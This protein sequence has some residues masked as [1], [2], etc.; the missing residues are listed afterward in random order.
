VESIALYPTPGR[1][2]DGAMRARLQC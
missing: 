1:G 2:T